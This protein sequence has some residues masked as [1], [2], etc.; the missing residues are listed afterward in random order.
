MKVYV[1]R[2]MI[3]PPEWRWFATAQEYD[4]GVPVGTGATPLEA[5]GD[6]LWQM[7]I[8]NIEPRACTIVW[9]T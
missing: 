1:A 2:D 5:I 4:L 6:L 3:A 8:E 7:D 9:E